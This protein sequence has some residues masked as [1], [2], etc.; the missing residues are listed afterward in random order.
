MKVNNGRRLQ[1]AAA[2]VCVGALLV[3]VPLADVAGTTI[4][5]IAVIGHNSA[6]SEP[7]GEL[8]Y[9]TNCGGCHQADGG[10]VPM[11]QP[12]LIGA[13]RANDSK[14]GVIDM[15]LFGSNAIEPGT[16]EFSNEMPSLSQLSDKEIALIVSYVRT[17]FE[18]NG[19]PV[20][21]DDVSKRRTQ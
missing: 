20:T 19:G 3:A 14:G 10:G 18:N 2:A 8:L 16:S 7:A 9:A 4:N 12:Q 5:D 17:H 1:G 21:A 13:P 11:M 15:I 6:A